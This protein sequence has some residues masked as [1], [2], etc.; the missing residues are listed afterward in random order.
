M[1]GFSPI[2]YL[3]EKAYVR[4]PNFRV[5]F[6]KRKFNL[7]IFTF[8]EPTNN[9][10]H[11]NIIQESSI[12]LTFE[13]FFDEELMCLEEPIKDIFVNYTPPREMLI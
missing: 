7:S 4:D 5:P 9:I 3:N 13:N 2:N 10:S 6:E 12:D 1:R 8:D 11:E